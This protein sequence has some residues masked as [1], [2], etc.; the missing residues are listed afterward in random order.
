MQKEKTVQVDDKTYRIRYLMT[1]DSIKIYCKF[2]KLIVP[3]L[4]ILVGK[5]F[6]N[7]GDLQASLDQEVNVDSAVTFL[8][9]NLGE[10]EALAVIQKLMTCVLDGNG[11]AIPFE[12]E[13]MGSTVHLFKIVREV[14]NHN[15][16]DFFA[17]LGGFVNRA[18]KKQESPSIPASAI[19]NPKS[20]G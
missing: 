11:V 2:A 19:S 10:D 7:L 9:A 8:A 5:A 6:A 18:F 4:G 1:S 3:S 17:V 20:G 15:Y 12:T 13:W 14:L 16:A